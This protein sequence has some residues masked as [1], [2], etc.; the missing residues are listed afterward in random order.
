MDNDDDFDIID[1]TLNITIDVDDDREDEME[2]E[3]ENNNKKNNTKT[4]QSIVGYAKTI[5]LNIDLNKAFNWYKENYI[6]KFDLENNEPPEITANGD[7]T[8]TDTNDN[9]YQEI[10]NYVP[11]ALTRLTEPNT[12]KT[13]SL[14]SNYF[15]VNVSP[16]TISSP[17]TSNGYYKFD[18][19]TLIPGTDQDYNIYINIESTSLPT[20]YLSDLIFERFGRYSRYSN[21]NIVYEGAVIDNNNN[22]TVYHYLNEENT[23][24]QID[25][26]TS[27]Y[28]YHKDNGATL[29]NPGNIIIIISKVFGNTWTIQYKINTPY[30]SYILNSND[31]Y[32][33]SIP[34]KPYTYTG[35]ENITVCYINNS[36]F[37]IQEQ[38]DYINADIIDDITQN[39][40]NSE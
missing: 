32:I 35:I 37:N 38:Y 21:T 33:L 19:N 7:Y 26:G 15:K 20:L 1:N 18:G 14:Y 8:T 11:P 28:Y 5:N 30:N 40:S 24:K 36:K 13:R 31:V 10:N 23:T 39:Q 9:N 3:E 6:G 16:P 34:F 27:T 17:I 2:E 29:N 22:K 12:K 4:D 25:T